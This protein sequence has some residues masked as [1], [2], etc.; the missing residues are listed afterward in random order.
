MEIESMDISKGSVK[1]TAK[2]QDLYTSLESIDNTIT[3]FESVEKENKLMEKPFMEDVITEKKE[4]KEAVVENQNK[5][6]KKFS[7]EDVIVSKDEKEVKSN[8]EG[9][10]NMVANFNI[11]ISS[12]DIR[13][14][15]L[16]VARDYLKNDPA[17]NTIIDHLQIDFQNE[18]MRELEEI[19]NQLKEKVKEEAEKILREEITNLIKTELK[20]YVAEI[21]AKIVK[22]RLEQAF[23]SF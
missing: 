12:D 8:E 11:Q 10:K 5:F 19:K 16:A 6:T 17:M 23:K 14:V 21:T 4:K 1:E 22:E 3:S 9:G 18:T 7:V 20:E 13:N 15:V 2:D